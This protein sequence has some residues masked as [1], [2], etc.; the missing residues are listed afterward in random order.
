MTLSNSQRGFGLIE[1]LISMLLILF[2]V[3]GLVRLQIEILKGAKLV[4]HQLIALY[5]AESRLE[6]MRVN[7]EV[8]NNQTI[9]QQMIENTR[10]TMTTTTLGKNNV[11]GL[12]WIKVEVMW[13]NTMGKQYNVDLVSAVYNPKN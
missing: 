11:T 6:K 7:D 5:L 12:K 10:F 8:S 2:S 3:L 13:H 1:V 4:Q 9:A